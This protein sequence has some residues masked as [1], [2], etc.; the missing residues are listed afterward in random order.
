MKRLISL[1]LFS[2]L[3]LSVLVSMASADERLFHIARSLNPNWVCYDARLKNGKLNADDPVHVYWHNNSDNPGHENELS[4][5]QR[6]M[7]YGVKV[8]KRGNQEAE[9]RLT[10]YKKRSIKVCR[11]NGHWVA[12]CTINNRRCILKEIYVQLK[13]KSSMSVAY[14]RLSGVSASD[15]SKQAE[16]IYNK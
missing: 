9:I 2:I 12:L 15:G 1:A 11:H 8:L 4:F 6:K 16:K 13:P 14:I 10:A 3:Q 7:A 5:F